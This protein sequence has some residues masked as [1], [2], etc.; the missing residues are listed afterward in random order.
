MSGQLLEKS[1][2][3]LSALL[4]VARGQKGSLHLE[5]LDIAGFN[6]VWKV[7]DPSVRL[8]GVIA[9]HSLDLGPALGGTRIRPYKNF[10]EALEDAL[11]LSQGMTY[12][13][14]VAEVGFGGGKSVIMTDQKTPEMLRS[15]GEAVQALKGQYIAAEDMGCSSQDCAIMREKTPYVVGLLHEKSSGNPAPFT[16]WGVF[17]GIQATVKKIYGTDSL[18]GKKVAIQGLGSVGALVADLLFWAGARLTVADVD[19]SRCREMEI[20][21]GAKTVATEEIHRADVDLFVPCAVGGILNDE[22][23]PQMRCRGIAGAANNQLL[24]PEHG[25]MLRKQKILYAPDFV[26]NAGGLMNVTCELEEGGYHPEQPREKVHK[27]Y[28][29]L[30]AIYQIAEKN[31]ESTS[32]AALSLAEYRIRYGL[33]KRLFPPVFHH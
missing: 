18:D 11:R 2:N 3:K 6:Q 31:Q 22:T 14:A 4:E 23:I 33:G 5:R 32:Q 26:I 28:D 1:K 15:F 30:T 25:E 19:P 21:Y 8:E 13:S 27:I 17:R 24:R 12:K 16:A 29:T 7:T 20:R 9:I 10:D